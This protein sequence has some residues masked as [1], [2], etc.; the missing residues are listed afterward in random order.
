MATY[1]MIETYAP[2]KGGLPINP[3]VQ[4][5]LK[6]W[7]ETPDGRVVIGAKLATDEEVDYQIDRMIK[8]LE[9]LRHR[10]KTQLRV[11]RPPKK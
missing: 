2:R 3:E 5:S 4:V 6:S 10:A 9:S 7:G 11:R 8:E 1:F